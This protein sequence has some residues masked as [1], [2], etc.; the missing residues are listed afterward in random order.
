MKITTVLVSLT[1]ATGFSLG[2]FAS[3]PALA[4][5]KK[6]K[7]LKTDKE[8]VSY[9][10]GHQMGANFKRNG[11]EIDSAVFLQAIEESVRGDKSRLSQEESQKI[12]TAYQATIQGKMAAKNKEAA[13]KNVTEGKKFLEENKKKPGVKVTASGL[14]YKVEK[15]GAGASPK[16]TDTVKVHYRGKLLSGT[17]FDSSY[18]RNEPAEF[19][20]NRVIKGWTE[21]LQ[22]MKPGAKY[23]LFIPSDLAYG[24]GGA[25]PDIGPN[26]VLHFDVE[27]LEVKPAKSASAK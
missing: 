4:Q 18:S 8:K 25:G 2:G 12:M 10:L 3:V 1:L 26:A 22:L 7:E 16:A 13:D 14:Q 17:E 20:V 9:I 11:V 21:A 5:A 6:A 24:A 15:E 23:E 19:E 27:L